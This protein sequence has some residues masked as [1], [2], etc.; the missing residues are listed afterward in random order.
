M[1][2]MHYPDHLK[3]NMSKIYP[4]NWV[5]DHITEKC[6]TSS[7]YPHGEEDALNIGIGCI[8]DVIISLC[9]TFNF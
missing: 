2:R 8:N 7:R 4:N 5:V 1:I 3:E 6:G 9:T